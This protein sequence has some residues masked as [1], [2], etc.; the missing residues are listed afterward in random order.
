MN[1]ERNLTWFWR[2]FS[3]VGIAGLSWKARKEDNSL[4][5]ALGVIA[6]FLWGSL[7]VL[8]WCARVMIESE[9]DRLGDREGD[10]R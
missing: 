7:W 9:R 3:G 4:A 8:E 6:I 2:L 1:W 10:S 5:V